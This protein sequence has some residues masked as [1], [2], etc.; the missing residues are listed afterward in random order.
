MIEGGSDEIRMKAIIDDY[1]N[2]VSWTE[3]R[4]KYKVGNGTIQRILKR[5]GIKQ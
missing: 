3:I 4:K 2:G 5:E 1:I